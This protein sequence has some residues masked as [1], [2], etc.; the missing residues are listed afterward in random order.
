MALNR[1]KFGTKELPCCIF[2]TKEPPCGKRF[3]QSTIWQQFLVLNILSCSISSN[4][5]ESVDFL[6]YYSRN[7]KRALIMF[8]Q[9]WANLAIVEME[10]HKSN[11]I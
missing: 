7:V 2:G 5:F 1:L 4:Y 10:T 6:H 11:N 9:N 3:Y 8:V